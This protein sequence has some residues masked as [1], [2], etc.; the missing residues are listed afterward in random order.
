MPKVSVKK[1]RKIK[2]LAYRLFDRVSFD[3]EVNHLLKD[4]WKVIEF[5]TMLPNDNESLETLLYARLELWD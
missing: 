3:D 5:K 2:T 4:G 1:L